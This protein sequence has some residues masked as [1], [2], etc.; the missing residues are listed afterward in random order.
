MCVFFKKNTKN[1]TLVLFCFVLFC[2]F[3]GQKGSN[4]KQEKKRNKNK[5][6]RAQPSVAL[7]SKIW[8]EIEQIEEATEIRKSVFS[9]AALQAQLFAMAKGKIFVFCKN[10]KTNNKRVFTENCEFA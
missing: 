6:H 3:V 2:L 10:T 5:K 1:L 8:A 9:E 4:A 7:A